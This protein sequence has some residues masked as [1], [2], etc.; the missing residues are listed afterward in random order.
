MEGKEDGDA[1]FPPSAHVICA[2]ERTDL[3][4]AGVPNDGRPT[5]NSVTSITL[6]AENTLGSWGL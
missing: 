3:I 2:E 4:I 6:I 1:F 5:H